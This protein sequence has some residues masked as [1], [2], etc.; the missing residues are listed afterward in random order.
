MK[1]NPVFEEEVAYWR[2]KNYLACR[3]MMIARDIVQKRNF[4]LYTRAELERRGDYAEAK[5]RKALF[6]SRQSTPHK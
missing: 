6:A 3:A 4:G 5:R 2:E 1:G